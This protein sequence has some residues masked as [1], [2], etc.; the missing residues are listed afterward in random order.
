[1]HII[2][3]LIGCIFLYGCVDA[4]PPMPTPR[5]SAAEMAT[6]TPQE[7]C[8]FQRKTMAE[9][10]TNSWIAEPVKQTYL[11]NWLNGPCNRTQ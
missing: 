6:W 4:P 1:M 8:A 9:I 11:Q 10:M 5:P 7:R 3:T 2:V